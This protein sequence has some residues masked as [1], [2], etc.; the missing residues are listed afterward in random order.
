MPSEATNLSSGVVSSPVVGTP[1][2]NVATTVSTPWTVH[3]SDL[4]PRKKASQVSV[5]NC[6]PPN[7]SYV[8]DVRVTED[9]VI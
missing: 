3:E 6:A 9:T 7:V 2:S 8:E 5:G 4:R 1:V